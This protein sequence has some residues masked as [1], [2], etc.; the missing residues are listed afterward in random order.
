MSAL[1]TERFDASD[2]VSLAW[3]ETGPADGRPLLLLHGLFSNARMNWV[4][5][6]TADRL[7][8]AGHRVKMLDFR[9]HGDS[10]APTDPALYPKDVMIRDVLEWI[11]HIGVDD[12]DLAGFSLG[13]RGAALTVLA[14]A[15]P[16][17]LAVCGM[18]LKGLVD[19][20]RGTAWFID[21]VRNA[22]RHDKGSEE[23]FAVQFMKTNGVDPAA[24]VPLLQAQ[25]DATPDAIAAIDIPTLV[26]CGAEDQYN[27]EARKLAELMPTARFADMPGTHM[28]CVTKPELGERLAA[29]LAA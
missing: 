23:Y 14:G 10:A 9:A 24:V 19:Q 3:H 11:A 29:F 25:T 16:R 27:A 5:F 26:L 21:V 15:T 8:A 7:A 20:A 6:G 22:G 17:R 4:K 28:S 12:Y 13:G 18:G 1:E 2:G